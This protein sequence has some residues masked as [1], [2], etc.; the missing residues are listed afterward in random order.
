MGCGIFREKVYVIFYTFCTRYHI[1]NLLAARAKLAILVASSIGCVYLGGCGGGG[2]SSIAQNPI[3]SPTPSGSASP[4]PSPSP[5]I[6]PGVKIKHVVI[7]VQENRSFDNLFMGFPLA[8]TRN[9]GFNHLGQQVNLTA[10]PLY[11]PKDLDHSA[12]GFIRQYDGGKMDGFDLKEP[13]GTLAYQYTQQTDIA[14]Y[15]TIA[16][17]YT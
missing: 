17:Q 4:S 6:A 2:S 7:I 15:W 3:P 13:S 10:Q 12:A 1:V 8:D 11:Q 14:P 9:Y 16:Q 5:T